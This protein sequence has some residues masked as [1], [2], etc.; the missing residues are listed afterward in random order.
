MAGPSIGSAALVLATDNTKFD[1]GL[2]KGRKSW[3]RFKGDIEKDSGSMDLGS[4]FKSF[5]VVGAGLGGLTAG[6]SLTGILT[7][8]IKLAAEV[9]DT[10]TDF[11]VMVGDAEKAAKLFADIRNLAAKTPL[12]TRDLSD[13]AKQ[14]LGAGIAVEDV[15]PTLG[16][17]GDLSGGQAEKLQRVALIYS[18]IASKGKLMGDELK[19]LNENT[20]PLT[21]ELAQVLK[22]SEAQV[23]GLISEGKVGFRELQMAMNLATGEGGRFFGLMDAKSR[24]LSGLFST[25]KDNWEQ[26]LGKF[27]QAVV[28]EFG[29]KDLVSQLSEALELAKDNVDGLRPMLRGVADEMKKI[30]AGL[31]EFVVKILETVARIV[32]SLSSADKGMKGLKT[33]AQA[34]WS[35]F[36]PSGTA[37][38]LGL[39][40]GQT[41]TESGDRGLENEVKKA[42]NALRDIFKLNPSNAHGLGEGGILGTRKALVAAAKEQRELLIKA[43]E[44]AGHALGL[45]AGVA[46]AGA[47]KQNKIPLKLEGLRP[48]DLDKIRKAREEFDPAVKAQKDIGELRRMKRLGGFDGPGGADLFANEMGQAIR[49]MAAGA[50]DLNRSVSAATVGSSEAAS[51]AIA[52]KNS[53]QF[54]AEDRIVA[55]I[56]AQKL[57]QQEQLRVNKRLVELAEN[58]KIPGLM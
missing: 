51:Q 23:A 15:L 41:V 55:A 7:D 6:L 42:A 58:G 57:I 48:D 27:G 8:S 37:R 25:L 46:L 50:P 32:D 18:Q 47:L 16:A 22:V 28:D 13:A 38:R 4:M 31:F 21:R 17:L 30:G 54:A 14:L 11:R 1:S 10:A 43:S 49:A 35:F 52:A 12:T 5:S 9:E 2:D 39:D 44:D 45:T 29:L 33:D 24:D 26:L 20:V 40:S 53:A 56:N 19:Q 3:K 36:G 34:F